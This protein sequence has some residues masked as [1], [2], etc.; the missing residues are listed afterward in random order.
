MLLFIALAIAWGFAFVAMKL[1]LRHADPYF[2]AAVRTGGSLPV[3]FGWLWATR[4]PLGLPRRDVP[5]VALLGAVNTGALMLLLLIGLDGLSAGLGSILL[6]TYPLIAALVGT[7]FLG[8]HADRRLVTGLALGF[9]GIVSIAGPTAGPVA[10]DIV[11]LGA[12][13]SWALGTLLFK[14]LAPGRDV[15]VLAA[16]TLVFGA[17]VDVAAWLVI[18]APVPSWSLQLA[19]STAYMTVPGFG[20][21]WLAWYWLLDRGDAG[22]VSA[23]LFLTPV[24]ALISGAVVLGEAVSWG[25]IA[26]IVLV[27][28][29]IFLV[30]RSGP[31]ASEAPRRN[32][33]PGTQ[34]PVAEAHRHAS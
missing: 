16:W 12:A 31:E 11:M 21:A 7:L 14:L 3:V 34:Q 24:F 20:F 29:G 5:A 32:A 8:E 26:G 25:K 23:Y 13:V 27:G 19:W 4:R 18:G 30:S 10:P 15:F 1:A 33:H 22:R 17:A 6:Y 2:L 9:A 28:L